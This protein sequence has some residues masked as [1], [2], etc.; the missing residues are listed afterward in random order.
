MPSKSRGFITLRRIDHDTRRRAWKKRIGGLCS[1]EDDHSVE[2]TLLS[3]LIHKFVS[4]RLQG[5]E[6][7]ARYRAN[8]RVIF[9]FADPGGF[10]LRKVMEPPGPSIT[11]VEGFS[12]SAESRLIQQI[13]AI[14]LRSAP[15][16]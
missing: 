2:K 1:V 14:P 8:W 13:R 3:S 15:T 10:V 12:G 7:R 4:G 6:A 5:Y 11:A 9:R 16:A